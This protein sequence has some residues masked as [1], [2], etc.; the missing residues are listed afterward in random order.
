MTHGRRAKPDLNTRK[1]SQGRLLTRISDDAPKSLEAKLAS[2]E[3]RV[4]ALEERV[5]RLEGIVPSSTTEQPT[6]AGKNLARTSSLKM[7]S[8]SAIATALWAG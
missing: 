4:V 2:L 5:N 8:S 3:A 6:T 7:L 1:E